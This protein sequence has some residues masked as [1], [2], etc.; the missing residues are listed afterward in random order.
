MGWRLNVRC[1]HCACHAFREQSQ[2][3]EVLQALQSTRAM[4][5]GHKDKVLTKLTGGLAAMAKMR[6]VTVLRGYGTFVG[7]DKAVLEPHVAVEVANASCTDL[8]P[9]KQ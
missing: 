3:L 7:A 4:L 5:R 1:A 2:F 6:K 9:A 8:Q